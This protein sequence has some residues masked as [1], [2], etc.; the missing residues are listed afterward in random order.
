MGR[1]TLPLESHWL[2]QLPSVVT[3]HSQ[4][5]LPSGTHQT[6][7]RCCV[8]GCSLWQRTQRTVG[9]CQG[10]PCS[11]SK[12]HPCVWQ[13]PLPTPSTP[14]AQ[15]PALVCFCMLD[16]DGLKCT[17]G[18]EEKIGLL[19]DTKQSQTMK[20]T[21]LPWFFPYSFLHSH[22][23]LCINFWQCFQGAAVIC[24]VLWELNKCITACLICP[25]SRTRNLKKL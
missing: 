7:T 4:P 11:P 3:N 20:I 13:S 18:S 24:Q 25:R 14:W 16:R 9:Q 15:P 10:K 8:T 12:G 22:P 6:L 2:P 17:W 21:K 1:L 23:D 19:L 5:G